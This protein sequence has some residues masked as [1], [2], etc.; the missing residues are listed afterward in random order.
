V[1]DAMGHAPDPQQASSDLVEFARVSAVV[2]LMAVDTDLAFKFASEQVLPPMMA[3]LTPE[4]RAEVQRL[5]KEQV[6]KM[7]EEQKP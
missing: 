2:G 6:R 7:T 5:A 1:L 3:S 4:A